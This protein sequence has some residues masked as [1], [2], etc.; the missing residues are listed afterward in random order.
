[1]E[2]ILGSVLDGRRC[3]VVVYICSVRGPVTFE[4]L[5]SPRGCDL[6]F[7]GEVHA[8]PREDTPTLVVGHAYAIPFFF[9]GL[10]VAQRTSQLE[11]IHKQILWPR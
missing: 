10:L 9:P 5:P 3:P 2:G 4:W 6:G 7:H 11:I 8:I 1:M